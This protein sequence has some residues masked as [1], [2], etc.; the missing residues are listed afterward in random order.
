[1]VRIDAEVYGSPYS[2][3]PTLLSH[4]ADEPALLAAGRVTVISMETIYGECQSVPVTMRQCRH[5][6]ILSSGLGVLQGHQFQE[7]ERRDGRAGASAT[8]VAPN[9]VNAKAGIRTALT[10]ALSL[11]CARVASLRLRLAELI[12]CQRLQ[13]GH[14]QAGP[15]IEEKLVHRIACLAALPQARARP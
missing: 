8:A 6:L 1:M 9:G 5:R 10:S 4:R 7:Q 12:L 13:Y 2:M 3:I 14:N 15:F 11:A